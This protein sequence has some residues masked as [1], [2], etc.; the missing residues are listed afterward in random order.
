MH[1]WVCK[2]MS[3]RPVLYYVAYPFGAVYYKSRYSAET[4]Q[5]HV[6]SISVLGSELHPNLLSA[7]RWVIYSSF[8]ACDLSQYL[9]GHPLSRSC[10]FPTDLVSMYHRSLCPAA[11]LL[12][13]AS[14]SLLRSSVI[15]FAR[16][17]AQVQLPNTGPEL[18]PRTASCRLRK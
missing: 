3:Q 17:L 4:N 18:L 12:F 13:A 11:F 7:D 5:T 2:S 16:N 9:A 10:F 15:T 1:I 6:L 8:A 14:L